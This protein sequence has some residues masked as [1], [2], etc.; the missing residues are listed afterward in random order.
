MLT[1]FVMTRSILKTVFVAAICCPLL[2]GSQVDALGQKP[3][4]AI[5]QDLV[6]QYHFYLARY[7]F[8]SS[9]I[10]RQE[11]EK[12]YR[13]VTE[14]ERLKG[15]VATSA[16]NLAR[17]LDLQAE[18]QSLVS[19]HTIYLSLRYA[20]N[21]RDTASRDE[22]TGLAADIN[23]R[24]SFLSAEFRTVNDSVFRR[25]VRQ[26]PS[27]KRYQFYIQDYVRQKPHALSPPQAELLATLSPFIQGWQGEF[28]NQVANPKADWS[29]LEE[30]LAF[31][32]I[33]LVKARNTTA[34]LRKHVNGPAEAYF[35]QYLSTREVKDLLD[36]LAR[37]AA[38]HK[39]YEMARVNYLKK[40]TG[41]ETL[42]FYADFRGAIPGF[43]PR[44]N[45]VEATQAIKNSVTPLG[46]DYQ[47]EIASL[48][49]PA[50]GRMDV[51]AGPNRSPGGFTSGF[52]G[53]V[54]SVFYTAGF[55]GTFNDVIVL[56]H[57]AGHAAQF[58]MMA[59]NRVPAAY[60]TGSDFLK[61]SYSYFNELL[62]VD[63]LY[64]RETDPKRRAFYLDQFFERAFQ[65]FSQAWATAFE[66]TLYEGV[67]AT[68]LTSADD[69]N[70][71]M[72]RIGSQYSIWFE[73]DPDTKRDWIAIPHYFRN[74][75][76]RVNY[77]YARLLA[78]KYYELYKRDPN[79][80]VPRYLALIRD[81]YDAP[82]N[83]LLKR[84]LDLD[85]TESRFVSG[86]LDSLTSKL[87]ELE[88]AYKY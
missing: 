43:T 20:T 16:A 59:A 14:L 21:I 37:N 73:M 17:A 83:V 78:L 30:N 56:T 71:L 88:E 2:F 86:V 62:L 3:F 35:N 46:P 44:F 87:P 70:K 76:Y 31:A 77:L 41:R 72:T 58:E 63:S 5:P 81:G 82:A 69:L 24:L 79:S 55:R 29:T 12:V 40:V 23:K 4:E 65:I 49:D 84:F 57:E 1:A 54:T 9:E 13:K 25:F 60:V 67:A 85:M 51:V 15:K 27:L 7:F 53:S 61:E 36:Q 74:P 28:Y 50:Y 34:R 18:I 47:R 39:R 11:R 80:F 45:I 66:Q 10:E 75:L 64:Q 48:L 68:K 32:L 8:A 52:P 6:A 22:Q 19:R 33:R 38:L 26:R 42:R